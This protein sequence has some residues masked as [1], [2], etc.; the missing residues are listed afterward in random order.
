MPIIFFQLYHPTYFPSRSFA[1][2]ARFI[3][4][5]CWRGWKSVFLTPRIKKDFRLSQ[6]SQVV[7]PTE[8]PNSCSHR[9]CTRVS[10]HFTPPT[11]RSDM[12]DI[13]AQ[14][15]NGPPSVGLMK[16]LRY[17]SLWN[18]TATWI[19]TQ[20]HFGEKGGVKSQPSFIRSRSHIPH[21]CRYCP[22]SISPLRFAPWYWAESFPPFLGEAASGGNILRRI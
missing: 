11:V 4:G 3:L 17:T 19:V 21:S 6:M 20:R 14:N 2:G 5:R 13:G 10:L 22:S 1:H 7:S 15:Q 9:L 8:P 18:E 12:R 16:H